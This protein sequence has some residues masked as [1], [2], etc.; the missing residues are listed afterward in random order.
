MYPIPVQIQTAKHSI[1]GVNSSMNPRQQDRRR[2]ETSSSYKPACRYCYEDRADET[3]IAPCRCKGTLEAIH[4]SC[5]V[6]W[7]MQQNISKCEICHYQYK[8]EPRVK[9]GAPSQVR[10]LIDRVSLLLSSVLRKWLSKVSFTVLFCFFFVPCIASHSYSN[11][12]SLITTFTFPSW[13]MSP[14][15]S[16]D[17]LPSYSYSWM[18][19]F[20]TVPLFGQWLHGVLICI[21]VLIAVSLVLCIEWVMCIGE[22]KLVAQRH[23]NSQAPSQ[24]S[25]QLVKNST[26]QSFN[27]HDMLSSSIVSVD[28]LASIEHVSFPMLISG[29]LK[30]CCSLLVLSVAFVLR[31]IHAT[32]MLA[33][34]RCHAWHRLSYESQ[35]AVPHIT[36]P[37]TPLPM[38]KTVP[39]G[40][41]T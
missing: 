40:Y 35:Y 41:S 11:I 12:H 14:L 8:L 33:V 31:Q 30:Y 25:E 38:R 18:S 10:H 5:L 32:I 3:L 21:F 19:S 16:F 7:L 23:P 17:P 36:N 28:S 27:Y 13:S 22:W 1:P 15:S 20:I 26:G 37:N 9:A 29:A 24:S 2:S 39:L 4:E 6:Q 34:D